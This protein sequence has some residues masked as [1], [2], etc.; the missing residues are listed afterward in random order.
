MIPEEWIRVIR[1]DDREIV[2]YLEML[3][4]GFVP[5]DLL[6]RPVENH[7][8]A[9][10]YDEAE[11]LL[12]G[13]GLEYLA[14]RWKL[15]VDDAEEPIYVVVREISPA[16]VTVISDDPDYHRDLGTAF[17]LELPEFSDRLQPGAAGSGPRFVIAM[18]N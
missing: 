5:R 15:S 4:D 13:A 12:I 3:D 2:G 1:P 11:E 8:E 17:T 10:D 7:A 14:R 6:G 16:Q 9:L 18:P